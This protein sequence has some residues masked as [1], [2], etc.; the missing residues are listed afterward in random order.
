MDRIQSLK[1][2]IMIKRRGNYVRNEI[3]ILYGNRIHRS[4]TYQI[5]R[6]G[7]G[8]T[9][10]PHRHPAVRQDGKAQ[11]PD[12]RAHRLHQDPFLPRGGIHEEHPVCRHRRPHGPAPQVRRQ[13]D[14]VRP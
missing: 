2:M 4:G 1:S 14:A 8:D 6:T 11:Q 12:L 5:V 7:P 13:S 10:S 3:R 9:G